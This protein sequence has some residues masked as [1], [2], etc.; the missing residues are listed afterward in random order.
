VDEKKEKMI[1]KIAE[2]IKIINENCLKI[3]EQNSSETIERMIDS[4]L[5]E[6]AKLTVKLRTPDGD[7]VLSDAN[8]AD[9]N[10]LL[11]YSF[12]LYGLNGVI[13][14]YLLIEKIKERRVIQ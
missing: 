12:A 8:E 7:V 11:L 3:I 13:Y 4:L 6:I 9:V 2:R 5:D 14:E 10:N 1:I